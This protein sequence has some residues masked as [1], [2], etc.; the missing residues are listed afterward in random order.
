VDSDSAGKK[1]SLAKSITLR[2]HLI[3]VTT[4]VLNMRR[5]KNISLWN[6]DI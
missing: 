5:S 2:C 4:Y 6:M 3:I 1:T